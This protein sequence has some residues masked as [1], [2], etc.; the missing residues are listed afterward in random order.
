LGLM[1]R[2]ARLHLD[3]KTLRFLARDEK[4]S[5]MEEILEEAD[6]NFG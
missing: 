6:D 4:L 1:K 5:S 2:I 3:E